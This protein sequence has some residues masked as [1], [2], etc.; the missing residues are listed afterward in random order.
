MNFQ[1]ILDNLVASL[2]GFAE[3][4]FSVTAWLSEPIFYQYFNYCYDLVPCNA[5]FLYYTFVY[6]YGLGVLCCSHNPCD[7]CLVL[8]FCWFS[9]SSFREMKAS[10]PFWFMPSEWKLTDTISVFLL[11]YG[12]NAGNIFILLL[13]FQF[14]NVRMNSQDIYSQHITW[15]FNLSPVSL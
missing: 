11:F 7:A 12:Y 10:V 6:G 4:E 9:Y 2:H 13:F 14:L 1:K 5:I 15:K 3:E 8:H